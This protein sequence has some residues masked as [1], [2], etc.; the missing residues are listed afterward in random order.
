[1]PL[2]AALLECL[3]PAVDRLTPLRAALP[4]AHECLLPAVDR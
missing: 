4:L 2:G 1:M 3:L